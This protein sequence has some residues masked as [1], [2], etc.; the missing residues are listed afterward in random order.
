MRFKLN[1][2]IGEG[3]E[4][5]FDQDTMKVK[6]ARL[7]KKVTGMG[8]R[9]FGEGMR[10][11]DIDALMGMVYIAMRR[12]GVAIPWRALDDFNIGDLD[13]IADDEEEA[14]ALEKARNEV[15]DGEVVEKA[16]DEF[17][18]GTYGDDDET[19]TGAGAEVTELRPTAPPVVAEEEA[20]PQRRRRAAS[21]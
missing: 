15:V 21:R 14:A 8:L 6:E 4:I 20:P 11:G 9:Q 10:N 18:P 13:V 16:D 5:E 1:G 17:G 12:E 7:L 2:P 3:R 19:I